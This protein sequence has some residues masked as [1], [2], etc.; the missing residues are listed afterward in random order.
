MPL[1]NYTCET[2]L[3]N[4]LEAFDKFC[5]QQT[6]IGR[7][8]VI[9]SHILT[10]LDKTSETELENYKAKLNILEKHRQRIRNV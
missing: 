3:N 9:G 7:L 1:D 8:A 10:I 6:N 4:S 5:Q 2:I